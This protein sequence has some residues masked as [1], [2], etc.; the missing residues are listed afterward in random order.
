MEH[1][2]Q[3]FTY[4]G[5]YGEELKNLASYT[6]K[7]KEWT[8]DAG[9]AVFICSDGEERL[10]PTFAIKDLKQG[11]LPKQEYSNLLFGKPSNS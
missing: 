10:I 6:A 1:Q 11:D 2:V 5:F 8:N 7:F 9:I 3:N 4:N